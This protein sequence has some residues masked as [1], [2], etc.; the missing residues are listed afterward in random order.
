MAKRKLTEDEA[1]KIEAVDPAL[2]QLEVGHRLAECEVSGDMYIN[3]I[4]ATIEFPAPW[5]GELLAAMMLCTESHGGGTIQV[6]NSGHN[7]TN[8]VACAT[9][10]VV[11]WSVM[12]DVL[13]YDFKKGDMLSVTPANGAC[14]R[15][16]LM[17][18]RAFHPVGE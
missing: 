6:K 17:C 14:G 5:D 3:V 16:W 8:A 4:G 13:Y 12:A 10:T 7:V 11:E 18:R 9:V 15:V 1:R 2:Q